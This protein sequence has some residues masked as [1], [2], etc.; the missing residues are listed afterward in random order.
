[1]VYQWQVFLPEDHRD[2]PQPTW[3]EQERNSNIGPEFLLR[4]V[5]ISE[6]NMQI[7]SGLL[8]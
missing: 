1:M 3:V 5:G 7:N 2:T 4:K 8:T 6:E